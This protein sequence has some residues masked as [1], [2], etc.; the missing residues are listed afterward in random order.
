MERRFGT[1]GPGPQEP[2]LPTEPA[3]PGSGARAG[4]CDRGSA[5]MVRMR[6]RTGP[7]AAWRR[8]IPRSRPAPAAAEPAEPGQPLVPQTGLIAPR[9]ACC[10]GR[11]DRTE[12]AGLSDR[13]AG[14]RYSAGR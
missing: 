1:E 4:Q 9:S 6:A 8:W 13:R 2:A 5:A 10:G 11:D 3:S 14:E 12:V 7:G